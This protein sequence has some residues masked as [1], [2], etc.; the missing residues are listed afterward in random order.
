MAVTVTRIIPPARPSGI[1]GLSI[2]RRRPVTVFYFVKL[3][4]DTTLSL[5]TKLQWL[6]E[7]IVLDADGVTVI[8]ATSTTGSGAPGSFTTAL[9]S[10]GAGLTGFIIC[11]GNLLTH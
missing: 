10:L 9:A 5:D 6:K 4:G 11:V 2:D 3:T 8:A 7:V 1:S